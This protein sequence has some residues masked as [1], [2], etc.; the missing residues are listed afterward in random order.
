MTALVL[1]IA[2]FGW[3]MLLSFQIAS[4]LPWAL[5]LIAI[6]V[7]VAFRKQLSL[8]KLQI[9]SV[10]AVLLLFATKTIG[11]QVPEFYAKAKHQTAGQQALKP[12]LAGVSRDAQALVAGLTYGDDSDLS[13]QLVQAMKRLSLTHLTAV[14]GAN[15][16][17]VI[18][19]VFW[20]LGRLG[21]KRTGRF[22]GSLGVLACYLWLVGFE[23]SVV[24]AATMTVLVLVAY[25][26]GRKLNP[27][28]VLAITV[29][30]LLLV[31]SQLAF[32]IGFALS[33]LATLA[34]VW[35][36]PKLY[37]RLKT[38]LPGPMA[39][40]VAVP[41]SAQLFC[42]PLLVYLQPEQS[43]LAVPANL[44]VE[45]VVVIITLLGIIAA[46]ISIPL[47]ALATALFW[48]ASLF[49][50]YIV[51]IATWLDSMHLP[52]IYFSNEAFAPIFALLLAGTLVLLVVYDKHRTLIAAISLSLCVVLLAGQWFISATV[53]AFPVANWFYVSCDVGQGDATVIRDHGQIAVIDVGREPAP[54]D[55]CLSQL[56]IKQ[57]DLLVITHFDAD[58]SAGLAGALA[59]RTIKRAMLTDYPDDRPGAYFSEAL[60]KQHAI[61]VIHASIG[62]QGKLGEVTWQVLSPHIGGQDS[63]DPNDGSI[64]M[65][66]RASK[67]NIMTMAD[68]GEKGQMRLAAE[69]NQWDFNELHTFP[70][71]LKVSHHGSADQYPELI[72]WLRPTISTLSV[73][74]HNSYGHPTQRTLKLLERSSR[75]TLRT[76]KQGALSVALGANGEL[77][78]QSA[79]SD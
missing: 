71:V 41:L 29:I 12:L 8:S 51:F 15:C 74:A 7:L 10:L 25:V 59:K 3:L 44:L 57:I 68:L 28:N 14:S 21:L 62:M 1:A 13:A 49:A 42:L 26:Y 4:W 6:S 31:F 33:S 18:A 11:L 72:E 37:E 22:I 17:I 43:L 77:F 54:I 58:H 30:G 9:G 52:G 23:P 69:L 65:L 40:L 76:D 60:L 66:W 70:L 24:R 5:A 46:A 48:L 47:P 56:G 19:A 75:V 63:E 38:K 39:L 20:V 45:P 61:P 32:S 36:A 53:R 55:Q 78:W 16:A 35:F 27:I 67:F 79:K 64:T 50:Q 34:L 2:A 73:G